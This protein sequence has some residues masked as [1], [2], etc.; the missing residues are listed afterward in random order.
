MPVQNKKPTS[1]KPTN[2]RTT[3]FLAIFVL[4]VIVIAIIYS[5]ANTSNPIVLTNDQFIEYIED[6]Y[7]D[8]LEIT[9]RP[10]VITTDPTPFEQNTG[11]NDG[12]GTFTPVTPNTGSS[13]N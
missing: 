2:S 5:Y 13:T 11:D 12:T 9:P 4:L 10:N 6:G 8:T 7:V 1:N 3:Q